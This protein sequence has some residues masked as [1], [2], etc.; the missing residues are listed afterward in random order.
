M[1][2]GSLES[3]GATEENSKPMSFPSYLV[4]VDVKNTVLKKILLLVSPH[5]WHLVTLS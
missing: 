2:D 4:T 5:T 3:S 1:C